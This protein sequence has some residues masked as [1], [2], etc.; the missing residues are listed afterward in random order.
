MCVFTLCSTPS[1]YTAGNLLS[2]GSSSFLV[3]PAKQCRDMAAPERRNASIIYAV[4]LVGE[5]F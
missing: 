2:I 5:L 1:R 3:G 4:T